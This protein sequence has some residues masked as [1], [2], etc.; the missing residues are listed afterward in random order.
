MPRTMVPGPGL[1]DRPRELLIAG[2]VNVDRFLGV[3]EF[4]A[5]DRT[6]PLVSYRE[7]LGGTATNL[8]LVATRY[9]VASGLIARIGDGFPPAFRARLASSGIDLRGLELVRGTP[10]P[11]CFIVEDEEGRQRTLIDQGPMGDARGA[12]LPGPWLKEYAWLH[13]TTGDPDFQIRLA[14]RAR[15]A[16]V[17]VA[18]DPAQEIHYRWD[19]P[20]FDA[21]LAGAEALFGNRSEIDHATELVGGTEPSSLLERVPLVVRTEGARGV[22]AF[23]RSGTVH[24]AAVR[25]ARNVSAV[26]AGEA[27]RGGFYAGW[28]EGEPL[29][30]ALIGGTR[31]AA[32]WMERADHGE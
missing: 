2:H 20:R 1:D 24:V 30:K 8:A 5:P 13:L 4:P 3:R 9:G 23:S 26:G 18:V 31:A 10:T 6:V 28:F 27:F 21:L 14:R 32:R 25:P 29:R 12:R 16:G 15:A 7:A 19:R 17:R 11:T 22:T